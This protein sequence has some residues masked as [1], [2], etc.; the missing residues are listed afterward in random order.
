MSGDI[1]QL[2]TS[3][4]I[5]TGGV[6]PTGYKGTRKPPQIGGVEL[7]KIPGNPETAIL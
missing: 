2:A 1:N 4:A 7:T 5:P 6:A 3:N